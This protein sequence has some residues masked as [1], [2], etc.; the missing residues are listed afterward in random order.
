M[1]KIYILEKEGVVFYVGKAKNTTRRKHQHYKT[2][3]Y[4]IELITID[5]VEDWK[6]WESYW[7]E[8]FKQWGFKLEN[9]NNGG[10]GPSNYTEEQKQ[11]MRKSRPG[12]GEKISKTLKERNHSRYYTDEVKNKISNA[13]KGKSKPFTREHIDAIKES[14]RKSS[15]LVYQ[16]NLQGELLKIWK[17]KGEAAEYLIKE[18]N[19][20]SNVTSQIKDCI[21]GRQKSAFGYLWSYENKKPNN[22]FIPIYQFDLGKKLTN[23]FNS[24]SELK[25]WLK[26]NRS[27]AYIDVMASKIKKES[28]VRTY[29]SGNNYYSINKNI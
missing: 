27:E 3:G 18:K 24:L 21:L 13:L 9:K 7:I 28:K 10:G 22:L 29:K 19:L 23:K 12:S 15:K 6:F 16:F 8:Q 11:K 17:S 1:V 2:Y 4:N 26:I 25:S 20:T 5:E 14:R